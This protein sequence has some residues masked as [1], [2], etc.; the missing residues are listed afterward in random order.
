MA[1]AIRRTA[2][3]TLILAFVASLAWPAASFAQ[4]AHG[5]GEAAT[6]AEQSLLGASGV[7][8]GMAQGTAVFLAGLVAFVAAVW[9]P[10][11][12]SMGTGRDV[13]KSFSRAVWALFGLLAAVGVVELSLFAVRA[14]GEAFGPGLFVEALFDTRTGNLW[15]LRL[16]LGLLTALAA[17]WAARRRGSGGWWL[18]AAVGGTLLATLALQSHAVTEGSLALFAAWVHVVAAA[19]WMGG[20]IG[21]P[22]LLLGPLRL[23]EPDERAKARRETVR[24][25]SKVATVSIMAILVTGLYATL[26]NVPSV[27]ALMGTAYG[28][29]LIMKLGLIVFLLAT[30]GINLID[31][32]DGPFGRMVGAELVLAVAIFVA[33]GFLTSLPPAGYAT[34]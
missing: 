30:G 7:A 16:G 34:P 5:E 2:V 11:S 6:L 12:R 32:G 29:A 28:R 19:F 17:T 20:L 15:I 14:S 33:A 27:P 23:M 18:A 21:F 1:A 4:Q 10:A 13:G 22:V 25:F 26:L 31:K 3:P 9:L 8:H 24:R